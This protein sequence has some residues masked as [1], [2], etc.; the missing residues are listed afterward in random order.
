MSSALDGVEA[1]RAALESALEEAAYDPRELER[2]EERLF[3]LRAAARKYQASVEDLPRVA[4][5]FAAD[6]EALAQG[7]SNLARLATEAA[8]AREDFGAKAAALSKARKAAAS[9]R[10]RTTQLT[11]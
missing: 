6:L 8:A 11:A 9:L 2:S 1:A 4:A 10:P 5:K 3:A 7:E